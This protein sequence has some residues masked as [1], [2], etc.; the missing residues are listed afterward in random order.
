MAANEYKPVSWNGEAITNTKLNQM[1]NNTQFLFERAPR[2][3]WT[4]AGLT[5]DTGI[6]VLAGKVPITTTTNN[7]CYLPIYFGTYFTPGCKP[8]LSGGLEAGNHRSHVVFQPFAN[9]LDH[10]GM[11]AVVA[12]E[13][14]TLY[15]PGFVH[16][17]VIGY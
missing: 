5:K 16:Y 15:A 11:T 6:K 7:Y 9:E 4:S 10:T 3:R 2:I 14:E 8:I 1:A 17:M 12:N 13:A